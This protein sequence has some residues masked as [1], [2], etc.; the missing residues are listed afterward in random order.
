M[1]G[2]KEIESLAEEADAMRQEWAFL[3]SH[4]MHI[5]TLRILRIFCLRMM[6]KFKIFLP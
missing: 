1:F 6:W 5:D 2:F 3:R 4:I